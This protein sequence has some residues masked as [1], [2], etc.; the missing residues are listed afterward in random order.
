MARVSG[1]RDLINTGCARSLKRAGDSGRVRN[2]GT[3]VP[4]RTNDANPRWPCPIDPTWI[5]LAS[6]D[7]A[8]AL[9]HL[10]TFVDSG[11]GDGLRAV[12]DLVVA[13]VDFIKVYTLLPRDAYFATLDAASLRNF[14]VVGHVPASLSPLEAVE[15]GEVGIP[16]TVRS[17][18]EASR[19]AQSQRPSSYLDERETIF[20]WELDL[21]AR[22]AEAGAPLL[23]GSDA[24]NPFILPGPGLHRELELMVEAGL[25]SREALAAAT[26]VPARFLGVRDSIGALC[27]GCMA[28]V[29]L[30]RNNP[31]EDISSVR[32]VAR[33][34]SR[35]R[36]LDPSP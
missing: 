8:S 7:T 12:E 27:S 4:S 26:S 34:V 10:A 14:P 18:W 9:R 11:P 21:V 30:L 15:A 31:L 20:A 16:E 19:Q 22:L 25:T 17:F 33:V 5:Y 6:G 35:G 32:Q 3:M 29:V 28:D 24:G 1:R 36:V 13:G 23:A 2:D